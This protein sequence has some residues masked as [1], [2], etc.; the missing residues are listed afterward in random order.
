MADFF[1]I[2]TRDGV[3]SNKAYANIDGLWGPYESVPAAVNTLSGSLK[4][5]IGRRFGVKVY[6]RQTFV[7]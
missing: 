5:E 2:A 1:S 3:I 6:D 4:N 7:G